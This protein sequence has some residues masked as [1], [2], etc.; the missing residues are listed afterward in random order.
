MDLCDDFIIGNSQEIIQIKDLIRKVADFKASILIYGESGVGKKLGAHAIHNFSKFNDEPFIEVAC[1]SMPPYILEKELFGY[2]AEALS[3]NKTKKG[4]LSLAEGGTIYLIEIGNASHHIQRQLLKVFQEREYIPLGGSD[5]IAVNCRIIASTTQNPVELV[6]KGLLL[7]ELYFRLNVFPIYIPPLRERREDLKILFDYFTAQFIEN[8]GKVSGEI[9]H[10]SELDFFYE[11]AWPDNVRELK[12]IVNKL[13]SSNDLEDIRKEL[14]GQKSPNKIF[15][16]LLTYSDEMS[17]IIKKQQND[18]ALIEALSII[19]T[20]VENGVKP[21]DKTSFNEAIEVIKEHDPNTLKHV[22]DIFKNTV[23]G[24]LT[25][26]IFNWI[27][28]II[29]K[30]PQ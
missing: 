12:Y 11:Y 1:E 19:K 14:E 17:K 16:D 25:N 4:K 3:K 22:T 10:F 28:P 5:S 15:G 30:F 27:L 21:S 8:F 26:I 9:V 29:T 7:E 13:M 18:K 23:S 20:L 2:K 6:E 24:T